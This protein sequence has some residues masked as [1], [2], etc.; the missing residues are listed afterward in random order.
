WKK[1]NQQG[2]TSRTKNTNEKEDNE[3]EDYKSSLFSRW[4]AFISK[5]KS[6]EPK[7][8]KEEVGPIQTTEK[9]L[10]QHFLNKLFPLQLKWASSTV[11]DE[12]FL[13]AKYKE[14]A[15]LK[16]F[17]QRFP[18]TYLLM[19]YTVFSI[20]QAHVDGEIILISPIGVEIIHL[21]EAEPEA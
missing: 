2:K 7:E 17:L 6:D 10:K 13:A 8:K 16:Y 3:Q 21:I 20:Q 1:N 12:S 19:Y 18:D 9:E 14:D 11:R 4:R 5:N 15:D